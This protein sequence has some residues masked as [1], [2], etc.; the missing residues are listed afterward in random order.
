MGHR[1]RMATPDDRGSIIALIREY[2]PDLDADRR[3]EWLYCQNPHGSGYTWLAEDETTAEAVG[4]TSLFP[5]RLWVDGSIRLAALG[6]DG[7]VRPAL[8][9]LGIGSKMHVACRSMLSEIG[10]DVMY[11]TPS[12]LNRGPLNRSGA[13]DIANVARYV[14]PIPGRFGEPVGLGRASQRLLSAATGL[15]LSPIRP[16]DA[17]VDQVWQSYVDSLGGVGVTTVRD[18]A[19]YEWRFL[20]NPGEKQAA[21]VVEQHG[22][23]I[24]LCALQSNG[25]RQLVIDL[26]ARSQNVAAALWAT[27]LAE[28]ASS[29][30]DLRL[31]VEGSMAKIA[32]RGGFLKRESSRVINVMLPHDSTLEGPLYDA[33]RWHV[34]WLDSDMPVID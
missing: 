18:S 30:T 3:Y 9:G 32:W 10:V 26:L 5:R 11:G 20:Q 6:G 8:R 12:A 2:L 31:V 24:A 33:S 27:W 29:G 17:R 13:R 25:E 34:T 28:P 19:F 7:Y 1:V 16:R 14:R 4:M 22:N 21:Y 23:P 15:E